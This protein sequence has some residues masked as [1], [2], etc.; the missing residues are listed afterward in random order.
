MGRFDSCV[1]KIEQGFIG[2]YE[3]SNYTQTD[4]DQQGKIS[5]QYYL[6]LTFSTPL[7]GGNHVMKTL[8]LEYISHFKGSEIYI[9]KDDQIIVWKEC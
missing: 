2:S 3:I 5:K 1:R 9:M 6:L 7:K 8:N 4:C